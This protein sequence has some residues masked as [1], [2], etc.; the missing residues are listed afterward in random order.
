MFALTQHNTSMS[1]NQFNQKLN[2]MVEVP[3]YVIYFN[4]PPYTRALCARSVDAAQ[5]L[6]IPRAKYST[7]NEGIIE[8]R[9]RDLLSHWL[10]IPCQIFDT[11]L[12]N[13]LNQ[14]FKLMVEASRYVIY[15]SKCS[16]H[17]VHIL[18]LECSL[19]L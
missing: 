10:L 12:K 17:S 5:V 4:T 19:M 3:G 13:Q 16:I 2:L 11:M 8:I 18:F 6:L 14:K 9:T 7:L 1:R 15:S